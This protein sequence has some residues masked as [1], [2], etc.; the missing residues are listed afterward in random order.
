MKLRQLGD[1]KHF[2]VSPLEC[3]FYPAIGY[4]NGVLCNFS[5]AVRIFFRPSIGIIPVLEAE[6]DR[7]KIGSKIPSNMYLTLNLCCLCNLGSPNSSVG[8]LEGKHVLLQI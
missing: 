3:I 7:G 8:L 4:N 5:L 6:G 1:N 2:L